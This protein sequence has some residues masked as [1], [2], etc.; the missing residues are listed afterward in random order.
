[1]AEGR[2]YSILTAEIAK[3]TFG[4]TPSEHKELKQLDKQMHDYAKNLEFEKAAALRDEVLA[5]QR[6]FFTS[7]DTS[8]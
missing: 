7:T 8:F 2:E 3:A 6:Y 1:M 4:L 5:L